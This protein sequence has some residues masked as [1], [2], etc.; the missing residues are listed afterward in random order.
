M[1]IALCVLT[2]VTLQVTFSGELFHLSVNTYASFMR[3]RGLKLLPVVLS[4]PGVS[5]SSA[6]YAKNQN[7]KRPVQIAKQ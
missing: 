7:L 3:F 2:G 4:G 6:S 5:E 1:G